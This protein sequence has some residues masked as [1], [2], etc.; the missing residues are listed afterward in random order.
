MHSVDGC[1]SALW[2]FMIVLDCKA[3]L[4]FTVSMD[5]LHRAEL[6]RCRI[7]WYNFVICT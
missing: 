5:V 7:N 3:F 4:N 1:V 6:I 2:F